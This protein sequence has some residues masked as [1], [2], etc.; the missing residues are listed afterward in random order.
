[1]NLE[2]QQKNYLS[3]LGFKFDFQNVG[4]AEVVSSTTGKL[5]LQGL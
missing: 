3:E 1:V 4:A 2:L 5:V